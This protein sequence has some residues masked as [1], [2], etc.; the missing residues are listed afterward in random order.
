[1]SS[2]PCEPWRILNSKTLPVASVCVTFVFATDRRLLPKS[3]AE[4]LQFP[5][6]HDVW[7]PSYPQP[8]CD[9]CK[10]L[11]GAIATA[12]TCELTGGHRLLCEECCRQLQLPTLA[13]D[14][15]KRYSV[16]RSQADLSMGA[17][18]ETT[19]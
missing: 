17:N 14:Q 13:R 3:T 5:V 10:S 16:W 19:S 6:L 9:A 18:L 12:T 15:I 11:P 4:K 1:M 7:S 2:L 8:E